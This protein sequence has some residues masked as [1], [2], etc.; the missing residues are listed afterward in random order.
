M[1]NQNN[2]LAMFNSNFGSEYQTPSIKSV[3]IA[4]RQVL[5]QSVLPGGTEI[6]GEGEDM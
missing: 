4:P 1:F 6:P 3:S 2:Y 5:C